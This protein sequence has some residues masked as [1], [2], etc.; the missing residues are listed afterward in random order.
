MK[1]IRLTSRKSE[2]DVPA[3]LVNWSEACSPSAV[4]FPSIWLSPMLRSEERRVGKGCR[5]Q[6][7]WVQAE[8]G[9]RDGRMT[10]VQTCALPICGGAERGDHV[11]AVRAVLRGVDEDD[12]LDEPE[13]GDRRPRRAGELERGLLAVGGAVPVDLVEPDVEIG[14]ASCRERV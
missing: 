7:G 12:P 10:G 2:I 6:C 14:R 4:R 3:G 8:D 9:I 13:V 5:F 11:V 1:M